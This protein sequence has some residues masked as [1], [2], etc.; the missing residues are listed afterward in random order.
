MISNTNKLDGYFEASAIVEA[1]AVWSAQWGYDYE[2]TLKYDGMKCGADR[3][4]RITK[5]TKRDNPEDPQFCLRLKTE[6]EL[7]LQFFF[8]DIQLMVPYRLFWPQTWV[9]VAR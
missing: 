9:F 4:E 2:L 7:G 1:D 5:F 6:F 3:F 8:S